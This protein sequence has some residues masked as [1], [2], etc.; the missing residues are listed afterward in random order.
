MH[1]PHVDGK[2]VLACGW[3]NAKIGFGGYTGKTPFVGGPG[4]A[5]IQ[6]D[7]NAETFRKLW[8]RVCTH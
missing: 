6:S 8:N 4:G 7:D 1:T 2:T 3:V 5:M